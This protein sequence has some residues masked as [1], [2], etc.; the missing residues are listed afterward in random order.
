MEKSDIQIVIIDDQLYKTD[1]LLL[2]IQQNY[3]VV[4]LFNKA[5]KGLKFIEQNEDKKIIVVLDIRFTKGLLDGHSIL[6]EIRKMSML[7]PVILWSAVD[8]KKEEFSDFIQNK[9]FSFVKQGNSASLIK[10]IQEAEI[11]LKTS[12]S[13][14]LEDWINTHKDN[15]KSQTYLMTS[16]GKRYSLNDILKA[17]RLQTE[18]GKSFEKSLLKLTIDRL[19]RGKEKI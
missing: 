4:Q 16:E 19:M 15:E 10:A 1:P 14:A 7:I 12:V 2:K 13:G 8:E 9:A 11:H 3:Q 18:F 5:E 6:A 17:V